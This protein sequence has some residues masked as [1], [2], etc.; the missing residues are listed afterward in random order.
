MQVSET[1]GTGKSTR[2]QWFGRRGETFSLLDMWY[3]GIYLALLSNR[4]LKGC[5]ACGSLAHRIQTCAQR[6]GRP[7]WDQPLLKTKTPIEKGVAANSMSSEIQPQS[8]LR[9]IASESSPTMPTSHA[10]HVTATT[11]RAVLLGTVT[12]ATTVL[13]GVQTDGKRRGYYERFPSLNSAAASLRSNSLF[14]AMMEAVPEMSGL[15]PALPP[16]LCGRLEYSITVQ[17]RITN[18]L[19]DHGATHSFMDVRWAQEQNFEL[20]KLTRPLRL[21]EFSGKSTSA[22]WGLKEACV[23]FAGRK[24]GGLSLSLHQRPLL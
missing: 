12:A 2:Y 10:C 24:G 8:S 17:G 7:Q 6:K 20:S 21:I 5:P 11:E 3:Y 1:R 23:C 15:P 16:A 4:F 14:D 19:L 13:S 9:E 18:A 22:E